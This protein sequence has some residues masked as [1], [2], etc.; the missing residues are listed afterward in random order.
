[1][2]DIKPSLLVA[3]GNINRMGGAERDLIRCLPHLQQ[4]YDVSVAT[5]NP[6]TKLSK[7]C[8]ENNI[9]IF[10]PPE[11]WSPPNS[12]FSQIFDGVHKSSRQHWKMCEGLIEAIGNF[13][14][15]HI[16]SGDGYLAI[17]EMIPKNKTAHLYLH[18]PHRGYHED[19][20]HRK[21]NGKLKRPSM[22]TNIILSKGRKNDRSIVRKF[23][24]NTSFFVSG[25]SSY[26][27]QRSREVYDIE[28]EVLH[29][30]VDQEE[31]SSEVGNT[32]NPIKQ[33]TQAEYV[34]TIGTANWAKATMET[35]SMLSGTGI[36][37]AHVGGGTNVEKTQLQVH[38]KNKSV[39]LWIAPRLS[40]NELAKLMADAL[41]IVSMAHKEPFG[42]TPI[43]AFS[44][45]TPAI[46]VDEGGF[47]DTIVDGKCGRLIPRDST[48]EW[49]AALD[50]AREPENRKNWSDFGRS[51]ISE[52]KLSPNE[53]A[54]K[55]HQI[56][57]S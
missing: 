9:K 45:G 28:C 56:L 48:R 33:S 27:A 29:P 39:E 37:L 30:C 17:M 38:A 43:E 40:S 41:A 5:L 2:S 18:E 7:I 52:L 19:S 6:S 21:L 22:I 13:D 20:L 34:V 55:I 44:I 42:L 54:E 49:H 47:R 23:A 26:S 31:Y 15:F 14:Y 8:Q 53:Q 25:N 35:I 51:R 36:S 57:Q 4:W 11:P 46:F 12:P 24:S 16:V 1:M 50:Q 32:I 3:K 10:S